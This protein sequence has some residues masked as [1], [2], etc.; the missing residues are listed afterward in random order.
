MALK[1]N[2]KTITDPLYGNIQLT[3]IESELVSTLAFQRL[4]N[5]KQLGLGHLVFPS[6]AYSRFSHSVG[7]CVNADR[8]LTAIEANHD[9][10]VFSDQE[11]QAFRIAALFHDL[12]HYPFS[13]TTEHAIKRYFREGLYK[14][15]IQAQG[16]LNIEPPVPE[17]SPNF[18]DHEETGNLIFLEDPQISDIFAKYSGT[19]TKSDVQ[20]AYLNDGLSTIISSDLDCDRLDYLKR[21]ALHS[22]APY[23]AVDVDFIIS[24]A[25]LDGDG[26]YCFDRKATRAADHLLM[27]RFYDFMQIPYQK[28]VAALEWSLEES[29]IYLLRKKV[30]KLSEKDIISKLQ[31]G[32]W[33]H[34]DDGHL[35]E[36]MRK[37]QRKRKSSGDDLVAL[38]HLSSVL[39]RQPAKMVYDWECLLEIGNKEQDTKE[40]LLGYKINE[41][42]KK[43]SL[44]RKRFTVW[45]A[46]F[47]LSKAGP[48]LQRLPADRGDY[49]DEEEQQLI[50]ILSKNDPKAKP[51]IDLQNTVSH[52]LAKLKYRV[53]RVY[54]LPSQE[55][56]STIK[57]EIREHLA[58]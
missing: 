55:D 53:L 2:G 27:S 43:L 57:G 33:F 5:V 23:G 19:I 24:K 32:T 4:H 21:T 37:Q 8:I 22:G 45:K 1:L 26:R 15:S 12:G 42:C 47:K 39:N 10:R 34:F 50:H 46:P 44:D 38:D 31:D 18:L 30:L 36:V 13:H 6:A 25:T 58:D 40:E 28:T 16:V 9:D 54:Y 41:V 56:S 17:Q 35:L 29:V 14:P 48:I 52:H 7:A 11:R 51:L 49:S 20:A 3:Q